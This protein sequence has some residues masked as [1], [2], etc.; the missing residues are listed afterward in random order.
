MEK[1]RFLFIIVV[2]LKGILWKVELDMFEVVFKIVD[3]L[4]WVKNDI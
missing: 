1:N 4:S 3:L 2:E